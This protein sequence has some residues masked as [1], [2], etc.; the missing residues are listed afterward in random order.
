VTSTSP[1]VTS[2]S[3]LVAST[4]SLPRSPAPHRRPQAWHRLGRYGAA[5]SR[6]RESSRR[7]I[8]ADSSL[9]TNTARRRSF[10]ARPDHPQMDADERR[11][12]TVGCFYLRTSASSADSSLGMNTSRLLGL[13]LPAHGSQSCRAD[14][15]ARSS[16]LDRLYPHLPGQVPEDVGPRTSQVRYHFESRPRR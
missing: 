5:T 14:H 1:L 2:T 3:V 9:G 16:G 4:S 12:R 8:D 11:W 10:T 6:K 15:R 13:I 7:Q